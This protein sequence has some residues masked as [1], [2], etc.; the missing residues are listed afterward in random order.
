[1]KRKIVILPVLI[2]LGIAGVVGYIHRRVVRIDVE[3]F[4]VGN[5]YGY[6]LK[7]GGKVLVRQEVIPALPGSGPFCSRS[8]ARTAGILVRHKIMNRESPAITKEELKVLRVDVKCL[9]L[10]D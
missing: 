5:G 7:S 1:M 8:D 4:E 10:A 3:V 9:D 2:I 6:Q